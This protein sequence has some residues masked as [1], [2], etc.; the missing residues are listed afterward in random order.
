MELYTS[1]GC[2][3][4]P[5]AERWLA[6]L[7]ARPSVIALTVP[8]DEP[9]ARRSRWLRER[10]L[11]HLQRLALVSTPQV[12]VQGREFRGWKTPA[13]EEVLA[14]I[15]SGP[16]RAWLSLEIVSIDAQS[17]PQS[18]RVRAAARL[19]A[20]G[21]R[22]D[23]RLYLAAFRRDGEDAPAQVRDW[24]GPFPLPP[25]GAPE[26]WAVPL[27]PGMAGGRSGVV[28]FVQQRRNSEVLQA[29]MLPS[30]P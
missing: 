12:L 5:G 18:L 2:P 17:V 30:C 6:G 7:A 15:G 1:Q 24:H 28:G 25:G 26:E 19:A 23:A 11:T 9:D 21:R 22:D 10:K 27:A 16:V 13:F 20:A 29:L 4:C 3:G 14:R 8:V